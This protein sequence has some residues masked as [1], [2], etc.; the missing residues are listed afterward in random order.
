M[1]GIINIE[2]KELIISFITLLIPIAFFIYFKVK[3][4]KSTLIGAARMSIQLAL[5]ALYLEFIFEAN[6]KWINSAWVLIMVLV[7]VFTT[8]NRINTRNKR[9]FIIPLLIS[10]FITVFIIDAFFLGFIIKLDYVFES[11]YFIP[12]SGMIIGNSI[13]H[14]IIGVSTYIREYREKKDLYYFL[15]INTNDKRLAIR[16]FISSAINQGLSPL[17]AAMSVIGLISLPGMMTGQILGGSS[18]I[19]AIKYQVIIMFAIFLSCTLGLFLSIIFINN[20]LL[21]NDK[22]RL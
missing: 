1:I 13:N 18:P 21:K 5:I 11:R 17:I 14:N 2:L 6:N 7:G 19:I 16:P 12:I 22:V 8:I 20:K 9:F 15:L 10:S 4:I 3:L